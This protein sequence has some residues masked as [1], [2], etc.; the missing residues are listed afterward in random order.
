MKINAIN[1]H[2]G[3]PGWFDDTGKPEV[4]R[5]WHRR[6]SDH[7]AYALLTYTTLQIA[8]TVRQLKLIDHTLLPYIALV[9]LVA[10]IIP[11]CRKFERRWE[12]RNLASRNGA[13]DGGMRRCFRRDCAFLWVLALGL[14]FVVAGF[15]RML[16]M[17]L[18]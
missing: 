14:P 5:K 4:S 1:W 12:T 16:H 7:I 10:A 18:A 17:M 8:V 11:G 2:F 15:A 13:D 6:M 9:V 3:R